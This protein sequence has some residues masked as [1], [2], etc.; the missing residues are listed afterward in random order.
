LVNDVVSILADLVKIPSICGGETKIAEFIAQWLE[1]NGLPVEMLDVKPNRADVITRLVGDKPGPRIMLSGH[2][3]TV[4]AGTGWTYD[5]FDAR[6][7]GGKMYGRG[8]FDM[9]AGLACLLWLAAKCKEEV[10]LKKGELVIVGVVDEEAIDLGT[11][12]LIQEGITKGVDFAMMPE[13]T[14]LKVVI[15]RRG[16]VVFEVA[17]HG[18]VAH[19]QWPEHGVNA[20]ERAAVLINALPQLVGVQHIRMGRS[21]LTTSRI[22]GGQE[23]VMLVPDRC[24]IVIERCLVPGYNSRMALDELRGL[25]N[26]LGINAEVKTVDRETPFCEPYEIPE[27]DP[28]VRLVVNSAARVLGNP[29]EVIFEPGPSDSCILVNQGQIPTIE[30]GP[31]GA[32]LHEPDE[33]VEIES[34]KQT[35]AVYYEIVKSLLG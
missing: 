11:Y 32:R 26:T 30:F 10:V 31:S 35:A 6:I 9:K 8:T 33:Y 27:N 20:I 17:V 4:E 21:T 24:R 23:N 15:A 13:S 5:P 18:K 34:V 1:K 29:P 7:E 19:T 28:H 12:A 14:N 22:E 3:D 2:M 25:A 16:R